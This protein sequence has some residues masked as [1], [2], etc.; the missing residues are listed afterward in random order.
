MTE[1][2]GGKGGFFVMCVY[3]VNRGISTSLNV[4][5]QQ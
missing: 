1:G 5:K 3:G 2:Q 4:L